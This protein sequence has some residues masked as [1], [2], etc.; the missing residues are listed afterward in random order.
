M[1][2]ALERNLKQ[3]AQMT[4]AK[5]YAPYSGVRVA[6]AVLGDN[7]G[8]YTG[9]NVENA[10]FGLTLC[11]ERNAIF[12]GI[13]EGASFFTDMV[14]V[15]DSPFVTSPCGSCR[16]V[17]AEFSKDMDLVVYSPKGRFSYNLKALL[18]AAFF[19]E[20]EGQEER[21]QAIKAQES[22]EEI[23]EEDWEEEESEDQ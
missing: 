9:V 2:D 11:A 1:N 20:G 4:L 5:A 10:S 7:D 22:L 15:S 13:T 19:M 23:K 18:P 16:Q 6:A 12:Q 3:F 21:K 8:I 17:M 14:I